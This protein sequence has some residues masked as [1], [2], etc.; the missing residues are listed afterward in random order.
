MAR[1]EI[2]LN[3]RLYPIACN[4]GEEERVRTLAE[5]VEDRIQQITGARRSVTENHLL[6]MVCLMLADELMDLNDGLRVP[7]ARPA[8]AQIDEEP[9]LVEA[10][11]R[12]AQR[13]EN[14]A[15]RVQAT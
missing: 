10:L 7:D 5:L 2:T 8:V 1:V 6:V 15:A 14:I 11:S 3:G 13:I 12:L 9:K 4:D